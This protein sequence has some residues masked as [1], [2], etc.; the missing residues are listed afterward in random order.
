MRFFI[1]DTHFGHAN[2]IRYS[3][4]PFKDVPHMNEELIR[5][6]NSVVSPNDE[7][8]HL[9]DVALGPKDQWDGLLTRLNGVKYLI[10]GNHEPIFAAES[11]KHQARWMPE[12]KKWFDGIETARSI[13]IGNHPVYLS[14]FPYE[15]DHMDNARYMEHRLLDDGTTL[16]HGHTH[17]EYE[18]HGIGARVS[19]SKKGTLQIHVGADAWDYTPVSEDAVIELIERS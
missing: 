19:R 7:V 8:F 6:W 2:I 1:S 16:I 15:A 3:N 5:R 18:K 13:K 12:F 17:A 14:H 9:G 4:R 11:A 10:I